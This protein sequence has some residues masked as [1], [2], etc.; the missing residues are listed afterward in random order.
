MVGVPL[1]EIRK[2]SRRRTA[3][4]LYCGIKTFFYNVIKTFFEDNLL[5]KMVC[6]RVKLK[7]RNIT[8]CGKRRQSAEIDL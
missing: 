8:T 1:T 2:I 6:G 4:E 7:K 3:A 5:Q